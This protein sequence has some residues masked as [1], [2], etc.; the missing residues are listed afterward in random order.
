MGGG[1]VK[2]AFV[3]GL[4]LGYPGISHRRP[5]H[6]RGGRRMGASTFWPSAAHP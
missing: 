1:D 5:R 2:Y 4:L 6:R 3:L